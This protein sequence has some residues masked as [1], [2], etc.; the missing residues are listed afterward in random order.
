MAIERAF[1]NVTGPAGSGKTLLI[2][3]FL[4]SIGPLVMVARTI[5]D[6]TLRE[7]RE[8]TPKNNPELRRYLKAG[9]SDVMVYRWPVRPRPRRTTSVVA[10][11]ASE[12][13][14]FDLD[15]ATED[16][17]QT[18]FMQDYSEAVVLEGDCP[19]GFVDVRAYVAPPSSDGTLLTRA[20]RDRATEE[21]RKLDTLEQFLEDGLTRE[22]TSFEEMS[23]KFIL[24][25]ASQDDAV[26]AR[27]RTGLRASIDRSRADLPEPVEQ[28]AVL[29]GYQGIE[30]ADL[31][32]INGRNPDEEQRG[33][34]M[35]SDINRLRKDKEVF[36]DVIDL[37]GRRTPITA[38]VANLS[39]PAHAG[40]RKALA[41]MRR[42]VARCRGS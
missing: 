15:E 16:F 30:R 20:M 19:I 32:I 2:E 7:P 22:A 18:D 34:K 27:V 17:F 12:Y 9:A 21:L 4:Q 10:S 25:V 3:R 31:V 36:K 29:D 41:R 35:L 5:R 11:I 24:T 37:R 8:A 14:L 6:D 13:G 33:M 1:I 26:L 38:V 28:W 39:D 40:T 42:A 23:I